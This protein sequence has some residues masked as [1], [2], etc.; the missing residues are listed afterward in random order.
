MSLNNDPKWH[1]C[2]C[3]TRKFIRIIQHICVW[4]SAAESDGCKRGQGKKSND[5]KGSGLEA[6]KRLLRTNNNSGI[7]ASS[8]GTPWKEA[9]GNKREGQS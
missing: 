1:C 2:R 5:K 4:V 9:P 7:S 6:G 3:V 8:D